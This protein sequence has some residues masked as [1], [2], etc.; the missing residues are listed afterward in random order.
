T[1]PALRC[2]DAVECQQRSRHRGCWPPN[3]SE[4]R[5]ELREPSWQ[6]RWRG[7]FWETVPGEPA[8]LNLSLG[9]DVRK[10][11]QI[12][13]HHNRTDHP[14]DVGSLCAGSVLCAVGPIAF[15][16]GL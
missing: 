14:H 8:L 15:L 13:L 7:V 9:R 4:Q 16:D 12:G 10:V 11:A 6:W 5:L 2:T 1:A 3:L